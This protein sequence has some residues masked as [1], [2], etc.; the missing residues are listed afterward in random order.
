MSLRLLPQNLINKIAAGE[1]IERPS[2]VIKEL[3]E[4]S[5]DAK[6]S[7][8]SIL[9]REG[10][11][12]LISVSDNGSGMTPS[13]ISL[14]VERHATSKLPDDNLVDIKYFGFRGEAL[15]AIGAVSNLQIVS[16]TKENDSGWKID[17]NGGK[18]SLPVPSSAVQG[19]TVKVSNLFFATPARL[20]FLKSPKSEQNRIIE[21]FKRICIAHPEISFK[22]SN[23]NKELFNV[24]SLSISSEDIR[25][26]RISAILGTKV[27]FRV[28]RIC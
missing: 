27:H 19:T 21:I 1:V 17:V 9:I 15:P 6:A 2:A 12:K 4:N 8:I 16:R 22:L 23:E 5:I 10:G 7:N 11:Q 18:I 28:P 24:P 26:Q 20:K 3:L 25:L 14:A 13:E